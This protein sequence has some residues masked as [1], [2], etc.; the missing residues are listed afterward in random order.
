MLATATVVEIDNRVIHKRWK[1]IIPLAQRLVL[2]RLRK[3]LLE[4]DP[5]T[6]N[7]VFIDR[8]AIGSEPLDACVCLN[9]FGQ[10]RVIVYATG[11]IGP[12]EPLSE[13][14]SIRAGKSS[15]KFSDRATEELRATL[16]AN[17]RR[18]MD[19]IGITLEDLAE[20]CGICPSDLASILENVVDASI[21]EVCNLAE[22][23]GTT[24]DALLRRPTDE[25]AEGW[26]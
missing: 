15:P 4:V 19:Q 18:L 9:R 7:L 6:G 17:V 20:R 3:S 23:L 22:C 24:C 11:D 2:H 12:V 10:I 1:L 13:L 21:D 5:E 25:R 8:D 26:N 14:D 16:A